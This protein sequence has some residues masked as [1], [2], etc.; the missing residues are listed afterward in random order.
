[1]PDPCFLLVLLFELTAQL[2]TT[3][4]HSCNTT[5]DNEHSHINGTTTNCTAYD[6]N[7]TANH[8]RP[9][10]T[11]FFSSPDVEKAAQYSTA[12]VDSIEGRNHVACVDV[13][14]FTSHWEVE[15]RIEVRLADSRADDGEAVGGGDGSKADERHHPK[16]VSIYNY[17]VQHLDNM[18]PRYKGGERTGES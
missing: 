7:G 17:V 2:P 4:Y 11:E 13:V 18:T 5:S 3:T 8:H 14:G 10:S 1:M 12:R 6:E 15:V 9:L 16:V